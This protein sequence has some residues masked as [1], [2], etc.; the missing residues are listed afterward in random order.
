MH[1]SVQLVAGLFNNSLPALLAE[2]DAAN[3]TGRLPSLTYL[4]VDCD[5]YAG[6][7]FNSARD[8]AGQ[9]ASSPVLTHCRK[10]GSQ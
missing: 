3:P 8:E 10:I 7:R 1:P 2:Q 6:A 4:H 5:L 9:T